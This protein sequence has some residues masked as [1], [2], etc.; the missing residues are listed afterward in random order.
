MLAPFEAPMGQPHCRLEEDF[1]PKPTA[2]SRA[3]TG[4]ALLGTRPPWEARFR[5]HNPTA[6][7][8]PP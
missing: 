4:A 8:T 1:F 5:N 3:F 2:L 7:G 6:E